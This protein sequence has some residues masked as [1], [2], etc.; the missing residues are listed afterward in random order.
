MGRRVEKGGYTAELT[1]DLEVVYRNPQG[2]RLKKFPDAIAG[3][4]GLVALLEAR[5]QLR[6]HREACRLQAGEWAT[7][8][9]SVPRALADADPL[10]RQALEAESVD[11]TDELGDGGLWARTYAGFDG[12]TL[13]QL[14]PEQLIPYRDR[15]MRGQHWEPDGCFSTG[16]PDPSDGALPFPERVIAAHPGLEEPATERLLLLQERTNQWSFVYKT[17]VDGALQGLEESAPGLLITLLDEM[18]DLALRQGEQQAA[19]AWF[20]RARTAERVQARKVDKEWLLG[21]YLTYAEGKALSATALRAWA[22]ELAVK[23]VATEADLSRFRR[24]VI[25][26]LQASSEL[27]PQLAVDV[28][29]LAKAAGLEPEGEL[30]TL[31][32]EMFA[33]GGVSLYHDKFWADCFKGPAVDL[34]GTHSPEAVRQV[35]S[36]RPPP[37]DDSSRL[38]RELLERTGAL[39]L[40]TGEVPGLP[41]GEAAAWLSACIVANSGTKGA[42]PVIYEIAERIAPKLAADGVPV[43]FRYRR[44]G[45][46]TNGKTPLDLIDLLLEHAAPV[47]DPPELLG[48][49]QL[50]DIQL[51]HRPKLEHLQADERF[52]RELRARVR[53]DL[54]M[55]TKDLATNAWYQPHDTK[56]W[57][58]IPQL[59]DN[60]IGHEE[61]RAWFGRERAK[62]RAGLD[63]EELVLLLGRLVH[64]G[65]AVDLL[66]KDVDAAAEFAAVDV[67]PLLLE[68]LPD[69]VSRAQVEELLGR[70]QPYYVEREGVRGPNRGPILEALPQ[71][72]EPMHSQAARSLVMAVNCRAG[73][74]RLVRRLTPGEGDVALTDDASPEEPE[75]QVSRQMM[76]L[77]KDGT[78]VWGGD[79]AQAT[80]TFDRMPRDGRFRRTHACAAALALCAVSSRADGSAARSLMMYAAHPFVTGEPGRWRIVHCE[81]PEDRTDVNAPL[82]G[83]AFRT[84]TSVAF[85]LA[86]R[87][88]DPRRTLW[89]YSP[90]GTFPEDGPLASAGV[91]L[92]RAH[93]LKPARP[94]GWFARFAELY[95]K[96]GPAPARPELAGAFAERLGLSPA[97]AAVLLIAHVPCAPYQLDEEDDYLSGHYATDVEPWKIRRSEAEQAVA[98]L[99]S[100]LGSRFLRTLYDKLLPDDPEQL[101]TKGPDVDRAAEWWLEELGGPLPVP[102]ALLPLATKETLPPQ[103]EAALA[104]QR[105]RGDRPWWPHLRLPALLGRLATGAHCLAPHRAGLVGEPELLALP[106]IAAWLAYRTPA[107]DPLRPTVGAAI[108]RLCEERASVPGPLTL[109]SLQSNYLMGPPPSTEALTAH[110]AVTE[111]ADAAHDMRHLRVDPAALKGPG[112]PLLDALDAYL[113]SVLPSQWL[114]SPSGLPALADLRLLLSDDFAALGEH[115]V[116]DGERPLGWEQDPSRSV[117]HLVEECAKAFGLGQDAAS[118]YLMLLALPD[119]S[120]RNVKAWTGW[121]AGRFKEAEAELGA[122]GRVLRAVRP[123]AGRS[124]FLPGAWQE[125]KPPRLPI[126]A[127][128]LGLLPLAREHR[129][130]SHLA[131]VPS[132]PLPMLFTRAWEGVVITGSHPA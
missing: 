113:D 57:E 50:Y 1:D 24:V 67:V 71:L 9:V 17:D 70:L 126:E 125:R 84:A 32:G 132:A 94:G 61:I 123:R 120:D 118:L 68:E 130:T 63:F 77:A 51:S 109:F 20:G 22:R 64:V 103:G 30:A 106:R 100:A 40:L 81:V 76:R 7:A 25:R 85:V 86:S 10:W 121:K 18:A 93:V 4:L 99:T 101:W 82:P 127:S 23:G 34:L 41:V 28:R 83:T 55:T 117:P 6:K 39:A 33:V 115:L 44:I 112:D 19:A 79:L 87:G 92:T 102:A 14:L 48:P 8:G 114:P 128:K 12:R 54:E 89:E 78:A 16:I 88:R 60:P 90:D 119:P 26:R 97:E 110:P 69:T 58:R 43:E 59:F 49:S 91:Q 111:V 13:T 73:L 107:G 74:E 65:V 124:L 98:A 38:W 122:S 45:Q 35:L 5:T 47:A 31:L 2:R 46:R 105:R 108:S 29:K 96:H 104:R 62:L 27:Y 36:L 72:G 3:A 53:A 15:L 52:A 21:R 80:T 129:S 131:A 75:D 37:F 11:L 116:T 42:R 56:G 66:L 95:R